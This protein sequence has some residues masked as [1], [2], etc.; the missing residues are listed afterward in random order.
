[1]RLPVRSNLG[2]AQK[3]YALAAAQEPRCGWRLLPA[4][5]PQALLT[6]CEHYT[7]AT[8]KR[9]MPSPALGVRV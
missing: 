1:M 5:N 3:D 8:L 2:T 7:W 6:D 9:S 4:S